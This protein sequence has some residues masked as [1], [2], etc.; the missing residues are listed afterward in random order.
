M[1]ENP[2]RT[3][4]SSNLRQC[5]IG[6]TLYAADNDGRLPPHNA[7]VA[8]SWSQAVQL[9]AKASP[10]QSMTGQYPDIRCPSGLAA[11]RSLLHP[12]NIHTYVYNHLW[13]APLSSTW[14]GD[15]PV[16]TTI[17][18]ASRCIWLSCSWFNN[19]DDTTGTAFG[20]PNT[21]VLGRNVLYADGHVECRADYASP[22]TSVNNALYYYG[23]PVADCKVR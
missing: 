14:A 2:R 17:Q 1:R 20:T 7:G 23:I 13:Y 6:L 22:S 11:S 21:H 15:I 12:S 16:M 5:Y 3:H 9:Y 4:C 10:V 19:N 8:P 18:G